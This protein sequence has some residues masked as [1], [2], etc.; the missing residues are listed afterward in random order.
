MKENPLMAQWNMEVTRGGVKELAI[1]LFISC[2]KEMEGKPR[3]QQNAETKIYCRLKATPPGSRTEDMRSVG[4][5]GL[6]TE[7]IPRSGSAVTAMRQQLV[8]CLGKQVPVSPISFRRS[9]IRHFV[10]LIRF[11]VIF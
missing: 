7:I 1:A 10:C 6:E 4:L 5:L 9:P 3:P 11:V 8:G 2:N